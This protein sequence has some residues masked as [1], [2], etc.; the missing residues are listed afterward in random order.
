[1]NATKSSASHFHSIDAL[2]SFA[3]IAVCFFHYNFFL[4]KDSFFYPIFSEGY[5][6]VD[7][8]YVISGFVVPYSFAVKNY[9]IT[10]LWSFFKKRFTRIEPAYWASIVLMIFKDTLARLWI[11]YRYFEMPPYDPYNLIVHYFHL[12]DILHEPYVLN[13]QLY[14]TLA[15]DWQFYLFVSLA[16]FFINQ[17]KWW[18]RYPFY[19]LYIGVCWYMTVDYKAWLPF[20]AI[21]FLPGI[22][23]F[24]FKMNYIKKW[25]LYA[26]WAIVLYI[27]YQ[28]M[29]WNHLGAVSFSCLVILL[30][31][32]A[33]SFISFIGKISYSLYLTHIF[34][35]WWFITVMIIVVKNPFWIPFF[36]VGGVL[37]SIAFAK[38]FYKNVEEPTQKWARSV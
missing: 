10:Q 28:K 25:E 16:F 26:L 11:D 30:F 34:S 21:L 38:Y 37:V 27:I 33:W 17:S 35:G 6:G 12:N 3:A 4:P 23:F 32:K 7:A 18:A 2:R 22:I 9:N 13:V 29:W 5:L 1:V 36:I 14:W 20:W 24:H 8:F 19:I 15:I 31:N